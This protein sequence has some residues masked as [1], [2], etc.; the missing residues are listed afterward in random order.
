MLPADR[1]RQIFALRAAG[2]PVRAIARQL[3]H[4]PQTVRDYLHR[5]RTPGVRATSQPA[6]FTSIFA[7]YC[8]QRFA[9]DPHLQ[10]SALLSEL[11]ELG[12][13]GSQ[14]TFYRGLASH[15]LLPS[16]R[17]RPQARDQA[18]QHTPGIPRL[19]IN[20]CQRAPVLPR[21]VTPLTGEALGSYL[22]RLACAN[23]LT[24][25]EVLTV[26]PSW[27]S[28]KTSNRDDRARHHMLLP[29]TAEALRALGRL[30]G[31]APASLAR[32]LPAFG[33]AGPHSLVRATT[34]CHRCAAR[35]GIHQPVPVHL[36]AHH[37][38]CT[39]H[40]IWLSDTGQPQLDLAAC[41]EI[42][43]AQHRANRLLRRCTPQELMLAY[44]AAAR[45]I[46]PW[47]RSP[48][49]IP[50]HWRHRLL[51]LQ[52]ANHRYGT[53]A[54]YDAYTHAAIY[55]DAIALAAAALNLRRPRTIKQDP[56]ANSPEPSRSHRP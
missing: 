27:F 3:G 35:R 55:P 21:S 48:A 12:F 41:P 26:L 18:P 32:A 25:T 17:Q 5:R 34:A 9:E 10:S 45:S 47:P 36:P 19:P 43:I 20:T 29:A 6:L 30:T 50:L 54:D 16:G 7:D 40:G 1:V 23:H 46:P 53:P 39:R 49:A 22:A 28:T 31:T 8:R 4:S 56:L 11:T 13:Q 52:T 44:Q 15:R 42:V 38:V 14:R 33:T 37:K 2:V 51:T 24:L